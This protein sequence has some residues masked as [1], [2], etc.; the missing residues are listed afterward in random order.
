M[1]VRSLST[2]QAAREFTYFD[3]LE[4]KDGVALVR[5][6]GPDKVNTI[7]MKMQADADKIFREKIIG[8]KDI[9]AVVFMSSKKDNF[10]A[11]ADIDMIK[12]V[13][14]K[15]DLKGITMKAHA[16][17]DELKKTGIPFVAGTHVLF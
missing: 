13:K 15:S 5:F 6:N 17:F 14:D 9:K 12:E 8:N 4:I 16:F 11:G 7:S 1:S 10:I 3:N 2:T